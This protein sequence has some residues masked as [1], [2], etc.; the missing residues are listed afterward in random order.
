MNFKDVLKVND[1]II[2]ENNK[3]LSEVKKTLNKTELK[4]RISK[5]L[6]MFGVPV[7]FGAGILTVILLK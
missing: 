7:A 5:R 4:L 3:R 2:L 6:T 1:K